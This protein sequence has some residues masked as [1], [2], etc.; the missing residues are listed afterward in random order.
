MNQEVE[1][2]QEEPM[3]EEIVVSLHHIQKP[4]SHR[5][6]SARIRRRLACVVLPLAFSGHLTACSMQSDFSKGAIYRAADASVKP[7]ELSAALQSKSIT[8]GT[9]KANGPIVMI[10]TM[11]ITLRSNSKEKRTFWSDPGRTVPCCVV[12]RGW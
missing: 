3:Q 2:D 12:H 9:L 5:L 6:S 7:R 8:R 11:V 10:V 1:L 4:H